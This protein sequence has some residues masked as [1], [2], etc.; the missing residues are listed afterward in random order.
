[1]RLLPIIL[2]FISFCSIAAVHGS[3]SI[4]WDDWD[5]VP[6]R[7]LVKFTEAKSASL[8]LTKNL[9]L[10]EITHIE[11]IESVVIKNLD[12][13]LKGSFRSL[14]P[15]TFVCEFEPRNRDEVFGHLKDDPD[16]IYFEPD[17][18]RIA[19]VQWG[20]SDPNDPLLPLWGM[21]AIDAPSAWDRLP[22]RRSGIRVAVFEDQIDLNH[23]DLYRQRSTVQ[24]GSGE[25]SDHATHVAGTIAATANNSLGVAGVANVEL[26]SLMIT[27]RSSS[28]SQQIS[29][30]VANGIDIVNMSWCWCGTSPCTPGVY[31]APSETEQDAISGA[32]KLGV[33]FVAAA[34]ND[35]QESDSQERSPVPASYSGVWAV[36]ALNVDLSRATFSNYGDYVDFAAPGDRIRSTVPNSGYSYKSGT[37]MAAPHLSGVCAAIRSLQPAISPVSLSRLLILTG[38]DLGTQGNDDYFGQGIPQLGYAV[39]CLSDI[40]A[41]NRGVILPLPFGPGTL[42]W[43][44]RSI[45]LAVEKVPQGGKIGLVRGSSF[46]EII[47]INKPCTIVAV[48]GSAV[49]GE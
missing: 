33:I 40:Y 22:V 34:G 38:R 32:G 13:S 23:P 30:A 31:A 12:D 27:G 28:F 25:I 9:G 36:S 49:I 15:Q 39:D 4:N 37:S 5:I 17:R 20:T 24:N 44:L 35:N 14:L 11:P 21:E 6:G 43:P 41:E 3:T 8:R 18:I 46:D 1:M 47:T 19:N 16:V 7:I 29:W 26:V 2:L 10:S 42:F 45:E 48:G